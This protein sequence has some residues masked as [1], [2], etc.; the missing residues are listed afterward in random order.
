MKMTLRITRILLDDIRRD[1]ERPHEFASERVGW[2]FCRFGSTNSAGLLVLAHEYM[3][4]ADDH[5]IDDGRFGA[6]IG[7]AAF[8]RARERT[9]DDAL[10]IF[11]VHMHAHAGPASPSAVDLTESRKFVPDLFHVQSTLPLAA[12]QTPPPV[13]TPNSPTPWAA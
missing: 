4:V 9:L 11:H 1:L 6:L 12:T 5:Y 7:A 10:G 2:V 3:P 8:R 13:A